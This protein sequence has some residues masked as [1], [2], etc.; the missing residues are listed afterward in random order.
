MAELSISGDGNAREILQVIFQ[1]L[2]AKG[3]GAVAQVMGISDSSISRWKADEIPVMAKFI[4]ALDLKIVPSTFICVD[5]AYL[6]ALQVLARQA[7][8][9]KR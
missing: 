4:T 9:V 7:L 3:Q 6:N 2:A 1:A 5:P 8:E